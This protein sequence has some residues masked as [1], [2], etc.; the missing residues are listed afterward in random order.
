MIQV[1]GT[2]PVALKK[3]DGQTEIKSKQIV[4]RQMTAIEYLQ[5]QTAIKEGQFIAIADLA[6]M[7]KLVAED[8]T[9]HEITYDMLGHSSRS[10]LDYLN[11]KRVELDAKEAAE[12][13][14]AEPE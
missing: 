9:E 1:E 11:A 2:L 13:S 10:N 12:S 4:M 3:L 7:T 6:T 5:S 14:E 8:G